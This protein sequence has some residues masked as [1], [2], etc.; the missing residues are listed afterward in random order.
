G[1]DVKRHFLAGRIARPAGITLDEDRR[2]IVRPPR[3][4]NQKHQDRAENC[5]ELHA[6]NSTDL[7]EVR[8]SGSA[9]EPRRTGGRV[10][11]C[12]AAPGNAPAWTAPEVPRS[13]PRSTP[14]PRLRTEQRAARGPSTRG[15][16]ARLRTPEPG[17]WVGHPIEN[18]AT[19]KTQA[20]VSARTQAQSLRSIVFTTSESH[21][22]LDISG[23]WESP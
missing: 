10:I 3:P 13:S 11:Q 5:A 20:N 14:V 9:G 1:R 8:Q 19:R 17:A 4:R 16:T 22:R 21:G 6:L 12:S 15:R 2:R 7:A 18:R 23:P